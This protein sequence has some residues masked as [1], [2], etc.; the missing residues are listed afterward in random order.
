MTSQV[1]TVFLDAKKIIPI[2]NKTTLVSVSLK[3]L[4]LTRQQECVRFLFVSLKL[5]GMLTWRNAL[6]SMEIARD[7]SFTTSQMKLALTNA[8]SSKLTML[9]MTPATAI[10]LILFTIEWQENASSL[11]VLMVD[12]GTGKCTDAC[13]KIILFSTKHLKNARFNANLENSSMKPQRNASL[14]QFHLAAGSSCL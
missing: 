7:G 12:I 11:F 3:N 6:L 5:N 4:S 2:T 13:A 10:L 14:S 1:K 9:T 8:T